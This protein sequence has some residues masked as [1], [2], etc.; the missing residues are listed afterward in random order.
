MSPPAR[1]VYASR[2]RAGLGSVTKP[3][4][5]GGQPPEIV[6]N[7]GDLDLASELAGASSARRNPLDEVTVA[8]I[9]RVARDGQY[10]RGFDECE[11][12]AQCS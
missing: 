9:L 1:S 10:G 6:P 5:F 3:F 7:V 4:E 8:L 11:Q 12:R 2:L